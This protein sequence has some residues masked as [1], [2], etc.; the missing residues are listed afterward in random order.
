MYTP[1]H[2]RT[3]KWSVDRDIS[4]VCRAIHGGHLPANF[5]KLYVSGIVHWSVRPVNVPLIAMP[6]VGATTLHMWLLPHYHVL[7]SPTLN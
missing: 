7:P 1:V 4:D 3:Q 5:Q 6:V 2:V